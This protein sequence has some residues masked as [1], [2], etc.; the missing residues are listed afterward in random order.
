MSV[1][2]YSARN[3]EATEAG[4][5][6]VKPACDGARDAGAAHDHERGVDAGIRRART[7]VV[8]HVPR[9]LRPGSPSSLAA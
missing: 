4:R 7:A 8:P 9:S 2:R 5:P 3:F 1:D 6:Q